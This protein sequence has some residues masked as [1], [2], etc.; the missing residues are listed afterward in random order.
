MNYITGDTDPESQKF[1]QNMMKAVHDLKIS[2]KS[3]SSSS[4]SSGPSL[5][6][7]PHY[8]AKHVKETPPADAVM[9]DAES[10]AKVDDA[11]K[12]SLSESD[13]DIDVD[14]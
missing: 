13:N 14:K 11:H 3:S 12:V 9:E 8:L 5:P 4:S 1:L 6:I 2:K 7:W 10:L